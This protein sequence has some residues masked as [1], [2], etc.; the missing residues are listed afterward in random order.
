MR[1]QTALRRL[2][3]SVTS[4]ALAL[5]LTVPAGASGAGT[6]P[7]LIATLELP[8]GD[9][10]YPIELGQLHVFDE[11]RAPFVVSVIDGCRVND[12]LWVFGAG[13]SGMPV[14]MTILDLNSDQKA[15]VVL[16]AYEPGNP[17]GSLVEPEALRV[18]SDEPTGGLPVLKGAARLTAADGRGDEYDDAIEIRSDGDH[19]AYRRLVR[20]GVSY[21]IISTGSPIVAIDDSPSFDEL[22][23]LAE[24]R[25]PRQIEGVAFRG[26]QGMLPSAA[27]LKKAVKQLDR[28]RVRRAFE[29]AKNMRVPQGIVDDLGLRGVDQV[30]HISLDL[31]TLGADAYLAQTGWIRERGGGLEPPLPV[32]DRFTVEATGTSGEAVSIP[33]VG[34]LVG[35]DEEG[36][37]WEY[38]ADG[39][40]VQVMD[41]CALGGSFWV[42]A[43]AV[44]DEPLE[45]T[46]TD[47]VSGGSAS[48][49][50][51]TEGQDVSRLS[52]GASLTFC[53]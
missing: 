38:R 25:T 44:T 7:D 39:V 21:P 35:S 4:A 33:L 10:E 28:S 13:L 11:E 43:G 23:L 3:A 41:A 50:L 16:P 9:V 37:M 19:D 17:I 26:A 6:D 24:G 36:K 14:P 5:A 20:G 29:T 40:L 34:P 8:S 22:L 2:V 30:D 48:Y 1:M 46:I 15:R 49:P 27:V 53:P 45:L 51:W 47:S 42:M 12:H 32:A 31:E 18:C 52:D